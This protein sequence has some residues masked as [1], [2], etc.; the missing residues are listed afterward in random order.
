[1]KNTTNE[2]TAEPCL[3]V[4]PSLG[5]GAIW[6]AKTSR[7]HWIDINRCEIHTFDPDTGHD[8][9]INVGENIGTVVNRADT[10]GGGFVAGLPGKIAG[11]SEN[12][13]VDVLCSVPEGPSNRMNDGKC[14]PAGRFWCGS[15][16]YDF[17]P[18]AGTLYMLDI[19][20][21]LY[22]KVDR[23][24]IS[25]GITW[26]SDSKKMF[27]VDTR[28]NT[29]DVFDFDLETGA[30]RSR[31]TLVKNIW[32]GHFDGM[33]IDAEDNLYVAIWGGGRVLKFDSN[34]GVLMATIIV[35]GVKN[36][37]SCAFGGSK[38]ECLFITT[39]GQGA[40]SSAEPNAG[41]VFSVLIENCQGVPAFLYK[42]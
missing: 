32:G 27:Y 41:N 30:I 12:G 26:S 35:P 21:K 25:N 9:S 18:G 36:V 11:I 2:L 39:S 8:T 20:H 28:P 4:Q 38:L 34:T 23:V 17:T 7:L 14:D 1:M 19:D 3:K 37:T 29:V 16:S 40:D 31:R 42:G 24:T 33:T 10:T 6:N 22:P 5:E 15:L 13:D